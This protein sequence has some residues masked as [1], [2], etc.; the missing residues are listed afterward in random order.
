M[1]LWSQAHGILILFVTVPPP[2]AT[3]TKTELNAWK[4]TCIAW[5]YLQ[6]ILESYISTLREKY[7]RT[8]WLLC[9]HKALL[10]T[11]R[12]ARVATN[13]YMP[14]SVSKLDSLRSIPIDE[15]PLVNKNKVV[16]WLC[17]DLPTIG[18]VSQACRCPLARY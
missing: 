3:I 9:A 12:L 5:D 7:G 6:L 4:I 18:H 17:N 8:Y 10:E 11:H 16:V 2:F 1:I 15:I 13:T 14:I